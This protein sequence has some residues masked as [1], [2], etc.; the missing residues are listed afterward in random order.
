MSPAP[1]RWR[2]LHVSLTFEQRALG[3]LVARLAV[4]EPDGRLVE[5][6]L[7]GDQLARLLAGDVVST[8]GQVAAV[9]R[10]QVPEELAVVLDVEGWGVEPEPPEDSEEPDDEP[11]EASEPEPAQ[12]GLYST[13]VDEPP[14]GTEPISRSMDLGPTEQVVAYVGGR[15]R[16]AVV[17]SRDIGSVLVRYSRSGRW[18][19]G[20][21]QRVRTEQVR[22]WT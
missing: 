2:E 3:E 14:P 18:G 7:T 15:W 22:R 9:E 10:R 21:R 5:V 20:V 19:Q 12:S 11:V 17:V 1:D 13:A 6:E 4:Y 8:P 16:D